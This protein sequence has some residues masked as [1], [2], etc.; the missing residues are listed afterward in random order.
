MIFDGVLISINEATQETVT[1]LNKMEEYFDNGGFV[2]LYPKMRKRIDS[3]R[4][5]NYLY[6]K[7]SG[8]WFALLIIL[9]SRLYDEDKEDVVEVIKD[10][11]IIKD[12]KCKVE[13]NNIIIKILLKDIIAV[14]GA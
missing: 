13:R 10:L 9:K 3:V 2:E 12:N 14:K 5:E 11:E 7:K 8:N 4:R 6:K 1:L